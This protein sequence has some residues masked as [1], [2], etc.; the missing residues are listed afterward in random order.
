MQEIHLLDEYKNIGE[1]HERISWAVRGIF[2]GYTGWFSSDPSD[3]YDIPQTSIYPDLV[4]LASG[5]G[6]W[7]LCVSFLEWNGSWSLLSDLGNLIN[8]SD[9]EG[10]L[11]FS[12]DGKYF[13]PRKG[14]FY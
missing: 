10:N 6:G 12:P 8:T 5:R 9:N 7:D 13:F 3:R 1:N 4:L 11:G 14:Y 2:E